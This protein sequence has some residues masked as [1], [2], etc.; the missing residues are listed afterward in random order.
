[1]DAEL[2]PLTVFILPSGKHLR[3]CTCQES[4]SGG[5]AASHL[6]M[7]RS[8]R[9]EIVTRMSPVWLDVQVCRRAERSVVRVASEV[10]LES[11]VA[12]FL[13]RYSHSAF[14]N[15]LKTLHMKAE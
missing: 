1:M 14:G 12:V 4:R 13:N 3:T 8:V 9:L 7:A 6:H 5:L 15:S 11:I 10:D 2:P